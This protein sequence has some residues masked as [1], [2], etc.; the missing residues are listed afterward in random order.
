MMRKIII[1]LA[2]ILI[3]PGAALA[4]GPIIRW[5]NSVYA[6]ES[7]LTDLVTVDAGPGHCLGLRADGS[8]VA[9]GKIPTVRATYRNRTQ[10]S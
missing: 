3:F 5:G 9:W 10:T 8:I 6:S 1:T 2:L 7:D 4:S